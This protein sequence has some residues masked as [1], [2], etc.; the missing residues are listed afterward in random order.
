MD[1]LQQ[2]FSYLN[3]IPVLD[4]YLLIVL[5]FLIKV[6]FPTLNV[7]QFSI[8]KQLAAI[9]KSATF[10]NGYLKGYFTVSEFYPT[11]KTAEINY[12]WV[13]LEGKHDF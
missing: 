8:Y 4:H 1:S 7:M 5:F 2:E 9:R 11:L 6:P 3:M 10:A 12:N 13:H